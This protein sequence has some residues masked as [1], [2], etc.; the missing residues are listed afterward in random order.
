MST[1]Q[2]IPT[3]GKASAVTPVAHTPEQRADLFMAVALLLEYPGENWTEIL[4]TVSETAPLLPPASGSRLVKFVAWARGRGQEG[5]EQDYVSTFDQKRRCAL[6]LSYYATGD[7]RARGIALSVFKDLYAA[8]GWKPDPEV[9][10]DFLPQILELAAR[11]EGE[12]LQLVQDTIASHREGVE[13]LH[14]ALESMDSPWANVVAALRCALPTVDEETKARMQQLI[15][16]GPP[17][18]LVGLNDRF[19]TPESLF[20]GPQTE[21]TEPKPSATSEGIKS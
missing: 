18:E 14:A 21:T 2:F 1:P 9:L 10:P 8:V 16:Q 4:D 17:A 5:V 15:R 7:T 11:C 12:D 3:R 20:A 6:E 19:I 13:V